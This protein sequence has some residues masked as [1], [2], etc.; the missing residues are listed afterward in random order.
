MTSLFLCVNPYVS[1][2]PYR[3]AGT[4]INVYTVEESLYHVYHYW[5]KCIDEFVSENFINWAFSLSKTFADHLSHISRLKTSRERMMAFL[6]LHGYFGPEE[7]EDINKQLTEWENESNRKQY[8]EQGDRFARLNLIERA[9][10]FYKQSLEYSETPELLNNLGVVYMK[11]NKF[12]SASEMFQRAL[13][14]YP[15][16]NQR[17]TIL[18]NMAEAAIHNNSFEKALKAIKAADSSVG[19]HRAM[20]LMGEINFRTGNFFYALDSFKNAVSAEPEQRYYLRLTDVYVKLKMFPL[21]LE[22]LDNSGIKGKAY[23]KKKAWIYENSCNITSAGKTIQQ[24]LV[25]HKDDAEL[26]TLMA[27][28][29]RLDYN[30]VLANSS[31]YKALSLSPDYLPAVLEQAK[32]KKATGNIKEYQQLLTE[33]TLI[34]KKKYYE[35]SNR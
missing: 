33:I 3:F 21:A 23:Y 13:E 25:Q 34:L 4:N 31:A 7:L 27:K 8:K 5:K 11:M 1:L 2:R 19:S 6:S 15:T 9:A 32:A 29:Y 14:L 16:S 17:Y 12:G 24:A 10:E 20:Y 18:L 28:Y 26:W 30:F 22:T 35:K